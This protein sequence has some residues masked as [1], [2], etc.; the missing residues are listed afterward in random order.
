MKVILIGNSAIDKSK[1]F[2]Q[3]IDNDFDLVIRMNRYEI[4]GYEKYLGTKT[5]I[6]VLNRAICL[7]KARISYDGPDCSIETVYKQ[8]LEQS[9]DLEYMLMLTYIPE[10]QG[11]RGE[12]QTLQNKVQ[13]W[14]DLRVGDTCEISKYLFL[15]WNEVM[16]ANWYKP[17]TGLI[18]I[19]YFLEKYDE[20]YIHNFDCGKTKH[21][22]GD[23]VNSRC[24]PMNS[25]HNWSF[26]EKVIDELVRENKV[27]YLMDL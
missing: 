23:G 5:N 4:K 8:K 7:G 11:N 17:A 15:K 6:W 16:E 13:R 24:E 26:D 20:I 1:E 12:I 14:K 10:Y 3:Q 9:K 21:Y 2:G 27:K 25:K 22:W 19:H 18:S